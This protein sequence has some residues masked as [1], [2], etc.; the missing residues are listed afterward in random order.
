MQ[1]PVKS[2]WKPIRASVS[3]L[4]MTNPIRA[5]LE[6]IKVPE[7]PEKEMIDLSIGDPTV[8]DNLSVH[9]FVK[10][11]LKKVVDSPLRSFHGY[12]HS[13]GSSEA[14]RAVAQ[15]F[16]S[17]ESPLRETDIILTS[18]CSGALEIAIKA[19]CNPGDNIL[20]P[21]PGF[22]LYQTICEH[23][24]VKWKHYNLLPEREWEVDLEQLSSLVD[25]RTKVIL[26]NNPSNP[27]GSVF[28]REHIKAILEIAEK[29]QLPIISDEVYYDMVFPSSGK[30]FES[31]GRVSE[32]VPV[33]VVGGIAK[34]YLVPGW[35]VGWI[36]IHDRNGLLEE[37]RQG[38]NRLTTLILGPNTL[39]QGVLPQMLHNTPEEFYQHSLSQLEANAQ[40]LVEQLANV[41]GLKVIKPSGAMYVM[42]G[43]EVEKFEDIKDDVDFTQKL[44][45]EEYV[46]VLPG[47]IFQIPNYV[48]LVICPTLDKLRLVCERLVSFS[49]RHAKKRE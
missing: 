14:K 15:K 44:L 46:L 6:T 26:V 41:P 31:F 27:C 24:D 16:T 43:I 8:Y 7:N 21:R 1:A 42:M 22:S 13:A 30:Q 5:L 11:E 12:V 35:R 29:H 48:R 17:P 45:A 39:V 20:L 25:E 2:E 32:D 19:F 3:S 9:P 23:L 28:S 34:R 10:E 36:Q 47:T 18:G 33:L 4:R 40:L 37:V 38:L 49:A